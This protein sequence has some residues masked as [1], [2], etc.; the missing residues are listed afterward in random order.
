VDLAELFQLA[1][2][3]RLSD[4]HVALPGEV[5]AWDSSAQTVNVRPMVKRAVR[6]VSGA[7]KLE[8]LPVIQGVR[9]AYVCAGGFAIAHPMQVGDTGVL[10]F[11]ESNMAQWLSS[12]EVSDPGD[13][14]RHSLASAVFLPGLTTT[15]DK[16][17][18]ATDGITLGT[19][20]GSFV[21]K[22]KNNRVEI[23]GSSDAAALASKVDDA[24]QDI[25]TAFSTF[26]AGS[27]GANFPNPYVYG[28]SSASAVLKLGS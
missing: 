12:G 18:I 17:T 19:K 27:G 6:T 2:D 1:I 13:L 8:S 23:G 11:S 21:L 4:L 5:E 28:G 24:L 10:L 25:A 7:R 15:D 9:V 14:R 16:P 3:A 20:N 26:V 22:V